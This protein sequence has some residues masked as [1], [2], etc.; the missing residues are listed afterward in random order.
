MMNKIRIAEYILY[1]RKERGLS[2]GEFGALL[3]VSAFAISKWEREI[4]YPD[5]FLLPDISN[6][7]GVSIDELM[8]KS[9]E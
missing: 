5:I 3:G 6:L 7:L 1:F 8:G 4:C 9:K 2:Q